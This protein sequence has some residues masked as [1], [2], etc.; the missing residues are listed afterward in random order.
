MKN[1]LFFESMLYISLFNTEKSTGKNIGS[2]T[3]NFTWTPAKDHI[4]GHYTTIVTEDNEGLC[5]TETMSS[6]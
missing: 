5:D 4:G 6:R 1:D 2:N 3:E